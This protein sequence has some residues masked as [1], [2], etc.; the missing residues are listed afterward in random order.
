MFRSRTLRLTIA[1]ALFTAIG[2]IVLAIYLAQQQGLNIEFERVMN[3]VNDVIYRSDRAVDQMRVALDEMGSSNTEGCSDAQIQK[4]Q[5]LSIK[6]EHIKIVGHL[7]GTRMDCSSLGWHPEP[8]ELGPLDLVGSSGGQLRL[9][10]ELPQTRE[11]PFLGFGRGNFIAIANRSQAID[12]TVEQEGVLFATF[13]PATGIIRISN[14]EVD[15][16]WVDALGEERDKVFIDGNYIVGV[17]RSAQTALTGAVAAVPIQLLNQRVLEFAMLL[18]PLGLIAGFGLTAL[19]IHLGRQHMSLSSEIKLALKRNEFFLV[20]QSIVDLQTEQCIGAEAL[21]RWRRRDG[22]VTMP[23]MFI[24]GAES[25]GVIG[26]LTERVIALAK[27]DM[28]VFLQRNPGF[29]LAINLS[30]SDLQSDSIL[31]QLQT[32]PTGNNG[33][34]TVEVTE[35]VMLEPQVAVNRMKVMRESGL[36]VALDDFGTGYS[37]LSY[38][39]TMQF[40]YLKIDRLFVEAID[41]TAATSRVVLHIIEMARTLRL[42][43]I[44]EGVETRSQAEYLRRQNVQYAQGWLF[45]RPVEREQF[46]NDHLAESTITT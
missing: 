26:L 34:V 3:Y 12:L 29:V 40:D 28:P 14:G 18:V 31:L 6:L 2:P 36:H 24:P 27:I 1:V 4:M 19:V 11:V 41:T 8:I 17:A 42:E 32:I 43:L 37:S 13:T 35:R 44:A 10:I 30:A 22:S 7:E 39:Q 45:G 5:Q 38:L 25:S 23:D 20:Y 9:D 16:N 33:S 15:Q 21:I 46:L